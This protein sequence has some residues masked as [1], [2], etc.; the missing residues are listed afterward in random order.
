M[1]P[2]LL[3]NHSHYFIL[4]QRNTKH[5]IQTINTEC[6][7]YSRA[8]FIF[9]YC[10]VYFYDVCFI[11]LFVLQTFFK[12]FQLQS[13]MRDFWLSLER[14]ILSKTLVVLH[15]FFSFL[16]EIRR[17]KRWIMSSDHYNSKYT[18]EWMPM[19]LQHEMPQTFHHKKDFS[20]QKQQKQT[21]HKL[22]SVQLLLRDWNNSQ[23]YHKHRY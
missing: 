4:Q 3:T 5:R 12:S 18:R 22:L 11:S 20:N 13:T 23:K 2:F 6:S 1:Y 21:K 19:R 8:E 7:L 10:T 16:G 17:S 15:M 9:T 14:G